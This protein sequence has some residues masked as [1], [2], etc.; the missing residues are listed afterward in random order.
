MTCPVWPANPT[1]GQTVQRGTVTYQWTGVVWDSIT[2]PLDLAH[3][4]ERYI[5]S[6]SSAPEYLMQEA[7]VAGV[8]YKAIGVSSAA[9]WVAMTT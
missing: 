9:D 2:G 8:A 6:I 1:V 7:L 4:S 5:T 3:I